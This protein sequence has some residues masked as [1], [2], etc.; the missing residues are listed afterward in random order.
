MGAPYSRYNNDSIKNQNNETINRLDSIPDCRFDFSDRDKDTHSVMDAK[1]ILDSLK[2][3]ERYDD[4]SNRK[5]SQTD[6][7]KINPTLPNN[8]KKEQ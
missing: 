6:P 3:K 5:P 4:L 7:I 8:I 1:E 2:W